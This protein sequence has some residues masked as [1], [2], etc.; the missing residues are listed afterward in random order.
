[1][2]KTHAADMKA[3]TEKY[4]TH[5][6]YILNLKHGKIH[7]NIMDDVYDFIEEEEEECKA[8]QMV[9]SKNR[10]VLEKHVGQ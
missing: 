9:L 10:H 8:I 3:F 4:A 6:S 1:V 2:K 7:Q 5:I